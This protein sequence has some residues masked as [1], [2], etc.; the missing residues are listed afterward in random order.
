[1]EDLP[2]DLYLE[3]M[4][5][6]LIEPIDAAGVILKGLSGPEKPHSSGPVPW[7]VQKAKMI[8]YGKLIGAIK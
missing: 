6:D 5:Y 1:M 2:S 7:Q 4:A 3:W 8:A